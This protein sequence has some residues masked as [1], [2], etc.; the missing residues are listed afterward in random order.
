MRPTSRRPGAV[1]KTLFGNRPSGAAGSPGNGDDREVGGQRALQVA[2]LAERPRRIHRFRQVHVGV[3]AGRLLGQRE[4]FGHHQEGRAGAGR[5]EVRGQRACVGDEGGGVA[6][7]HAAC[8]AR[9]VMASARSIRSQPA[10]GR[11]A[12]SLITCRNARPPGW[13]WN[14]PSR[15]RLMCLSATP[16]A[17]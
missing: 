16:R 13:P 17:R 4:A 8:S 11:G 12:P 14:R 10:S 6:G 3:V 7:D 9:T 15:W 5:A 2:V 1:A